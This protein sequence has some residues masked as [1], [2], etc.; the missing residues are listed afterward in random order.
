M[1]NLRIEIPRVDARSL[2][3][4]VY[5]FEKACGISGYLLKFTRFP[6]SEN[7]QGIRVRRFHLAVFSHHVGN[8]RDISVPRYIPG[9]Q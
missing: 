6:V 5:F 9:L 4:L 3:A 1:P 8:S 7:V 2:G